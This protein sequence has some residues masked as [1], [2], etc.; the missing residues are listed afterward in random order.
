MECELS[1]ACIHIRPLSHLANAMSYL[2]TLAQPHYTLLCKSTPVQPNRAG[3]CFERRFTM[4]MNDQNFI[5]ISDTL[6][7]KRI[8][9]VGNFMLK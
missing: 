3:V 1:K 8:I 2:H 4:Q 6:A 5:L 9:Q 7:R